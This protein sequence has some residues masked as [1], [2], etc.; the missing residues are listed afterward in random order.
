MYGSNTTT[1]TTINE[2]DE[3]EVKKTLNFIE[4][5]S[6]NGFDDS[7]S[8]HNMEKR[9]RAQSFLSSDGGF[10]VEDLDSSTS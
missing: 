6:L 4:C 3:R 9:E 5:M 8:D 7:D 2:A 1:P 10:V